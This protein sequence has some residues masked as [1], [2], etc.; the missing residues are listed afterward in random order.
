MF[1][2][3]DSDWFNITLEIVFLIL[4]S[5][6]VKKYFETRK[7]EYIINIVLT[8]GF[9]IW[10]LYPYYNSYVGWKENQKSEMLSHC[11]GDESSTKLCKC[12][13]DAT[14]KE[15]TYDEYRSLDKNSSDYKKFVKDAK[16]ECLDDSWF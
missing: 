10:A 4:I 3:L 7:W 9:A 11:S 2:F 12:L 6:D 15:Y 13:D 5:Y 1:D 16:E 8:I 14:F